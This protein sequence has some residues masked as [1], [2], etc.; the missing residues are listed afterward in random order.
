MLKQLNSISDVVFPVLKVSLLHLATQR[1]WNAIVRSLSAH[2]ASVP[3]LPSVVLLIQI[4]RY[5]YVAI[6]DTLPKLGRC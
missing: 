1:S 2:T 6:A 3:V 5:C 4:S